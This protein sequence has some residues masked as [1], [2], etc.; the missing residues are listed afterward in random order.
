MEGEVQRI[1]RWAQVLTGRELDTY[2]TVRRLD[3][4]TRQQYG[5]ELE[6]LGG[7]PLP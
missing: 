7:A 3:A 2:G 6:K 1:V 4:A 5:E